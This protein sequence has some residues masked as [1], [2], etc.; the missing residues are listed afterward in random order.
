MVDRFEDDEHDK[1]L[2]EDKHGFQS[3]GGHRND[4][5]ESEP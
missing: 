1:E 3:S 4:K 2:D 5:T